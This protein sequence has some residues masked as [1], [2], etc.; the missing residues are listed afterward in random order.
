MSIQ[1]IDGKTL[2]EALADNYKRSLPKAKRGVAWTMDT[3]SQ[4]VKLRYP[5]IRVAEGQEWKG[6]AKKVDG[7]TVNQIYTFICEDHREYNAQACHV[8][9]QTD[10]HTGSQCPGCNAAKA[11]VETK[12]RNDKI[13]AAFVGQTTSDGHLILEH[14]GYRQTPTHKKKGRIGQAIYR[15]KCSVCGNEDAVARG[16]HLKTPGNTAHCGCGSK[17]DCRIKFTQNEKKAEAPC[18]V[19][20]FSTI[21]NTG[22]KLGISNNIKRRASENYDEQLFVSQS[23]PRSTCWAVEQVMHHRLRTLGLQYD[24][25][26]VPA[27]QTGEE[28]GGTEVFYNFDLAWVISQIND[29]IAEAE[30]IG[31]QA[32][33]DRY[34]PLL[35]QTHLQLFY[36]EGKRIRQS[37]GEGYIGHQ[38][39]SVFTLV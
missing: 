25:T 38:H 9:N 3:F 15:Y 4:W 8:L 23:L 35:Q 28:A 20:I 39:N 21:A 12:A 7:K 22:I 19:Y 27:F 1:T 31:W 30:T 6:V 10:D 34:I 36:W 11:K 32:L 14:V 13:T 26:D 18:F 2:C 24:L 37:S 33:I 29:L 16:V 5:E 17:R